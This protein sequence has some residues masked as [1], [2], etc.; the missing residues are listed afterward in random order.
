MKKMITLLLLLLSM[1]MLCSC[2]EVMQQVETV[3]QQI[4]VEA[5][6]TN[7]IENINWAEL[8]TYSQQGYD[9]LVEHFPAL[10]SENIKAFL[11][12]NGLELLNSYVESS[13]TE[14]QDNAKKLGQIIKILN[15]ELS[16]EVD[17]VIAE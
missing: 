16:D 7:A 2:S 10:K 14:M 8:K 4:D 5:L 9:T 12:A 3:A 1:T 13:D 6:V 17:S 11:K 15:P